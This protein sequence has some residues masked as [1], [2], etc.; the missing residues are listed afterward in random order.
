MKIG[1]NRI[2][3]AIVALAVLTGLSI[4]FL[5]K[6]PARRRAKLN[7]PG[8]SVPLPDAA[9]LSALPID[10]WSQYLNAQQSAGAWERL[11]SDLEEFRSTKQSQYEQY[12]LGYLHARVKIEAGEYDDGRELLQPYVEDPAWRDLALFHAAEAAAADDEVE[13]AIAL[14]ERLIATEWDSIYRSET[15]ESLLDEYLAEEQWTK[16]RAFQTAYAVRLDPSSRRIVDA[17]LVAADLEQDQPQ[18]AVARAIRIAGTNGADDAADRAFRLLDEEKLLEGLPAAQ[19]AMFGEVARSHRH[20]KRAIAL[21]DGA[22][23][24][25]PQE[26]ND[27]TFSL[28]RAYFGSELFA[29]A[30][31]V[32]LE[33]AARSS[34]PAEQ[35]SFFFHAARCSQLLGDDR[36]GEE[37]LTKAIAVKGRFPATAAALTQRART[38]ARI[39]RL[40]Q[41]ASD[42]ELLIRLFPREKAAIDAAIAVAAVAFARRDF[43]MANRLL[44]FAARQGPGDAA[45]AEIA[46][47]RGRIAEPGDPA[48]AI[49]LHLAVMRADTPTHFAYFARRRVWSHLAA[50]AGRRRTALARRFSEASGTGRIDDARRIATDLVLLASPATLRED[51]ERLRG[52]YRQSEGFDRIVDLA[53]APLPRFPLESTDRAPLLVA[54]G[55]QDDAS[56][57]IRSTYPLRDPASALAQSYALHLGGASRPSIYAAEVLMQ[58]VPDDF[59]PAL[60]PPLLQQMLYPRYYLAEIAEDADRY[61]A[62]PRLILAIMREESRFNPRAKSFAAARGLLQF[63]I[64]TARDV[65]GSIGLV[66]LEPDDLYDPRTIIRLGAKYVGDLLEQFGGN[67]YL[68]ASAYNAGPYQTR[69]WARLSPSGDNDAFLSSV[70]F[71]ETKNYIRKVLNSY[72]RYGEIYGTAP[73]TGGLRAEP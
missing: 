7:L 4:F 56:D 72:E 64:T 33:G 43:A 31:R 53:P 49:D 6:R 67:P 70:N 44:D 3:V 21:I 23:R 2:V 19:R 63:I 73:P 46:Y 54:L 39:G 59:V 62:D 57:W 68:V 52:I 12:D 14:R 27:L 17:A 15:V 11:D 66:E 32:Y 37:L 55:L 58:Q 69:L 41:A 30:R 16:L 1:R 51:L 42:L 50:E 40:A 65:G 61:D 22:R 18:K 48:R 13:E 5:A 25:L 45:R 26:W 29:D 24:E 20:F 36:S 35:A 71:D 34:R 28:G 60:L 38:R 10:Q 9:R 47:W 8:T